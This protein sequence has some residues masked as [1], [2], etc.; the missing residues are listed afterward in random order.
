MFAGELQIAADQWNVIDKEFDLVRCQ[1]HF[2]IS[3]RG[4]Q[5]A[6]VRVATV[7]RG[8]NQGGTRDCAS[9]MSGG[10]IARRPLNADFN[11]LRSTFTVAHNGFRQILSNTGQ[12]LLQGLL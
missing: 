1:W 3:D 10:V 5:T 4:N 11:K 2:R 9:D 7:D 8:F 12:S 6:P